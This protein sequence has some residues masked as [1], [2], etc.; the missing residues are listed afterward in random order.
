MAREFERKISLPSRLDEEK[1]AEVAVALLS[2]TLHDGG[3][4]EP[5]NRRHRARRQYPAAP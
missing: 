1:L 3:R 2:S 5:S 4:V